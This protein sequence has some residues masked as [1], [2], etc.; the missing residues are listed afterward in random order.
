MSDRNINLITLTATNN[1]VQHKTL[2]LSRNISS[3]LKRVN[4]EQ[5]YKV[6]MTYFD[7]KLFVAVPLDNSIGCNTLLVYNFVTENWF[8]EWTFEGTLNLNI[9]GLAVATYLGLQR[10]HAITDDGR[11][12]VFDSGQNDISGT[13]VADIS[14]SV[15]TRAYNFE[16][17]NATQS[18][19]WVDLG[20]NR[21]N[22]SITSFTDGASESSEILSDQ[23]Y[24][25]TE[26][27][28]FND[29]TYDVTNANNDFNRAYRKDY[30]SGPLAAGST[31]GLPTTGLQ[32]GTGFLPEQ[33]QSYRVPLI[34][35]RQGRLSWL[36]VTNTTGFI[37]IKG[38]GFEN[39][40][41]QRSS[42]IQ[43]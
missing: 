31:Q 12:F 20:T 36:E 11:I 40:A 41:G 16:G 24:A 26:S 33:V 42:L 22:F 27:W 23:T 38:L 15:V 1:S 39:H 5:A 19:L 32:C 28:I 37:Q 13:T 4:W 3:I 6:S 35:R 9:Q 7:N 21:P 29:S 43:V 34:T 18:R 14:T 30:S 25:R 10:L 8:G 2:P 17:V